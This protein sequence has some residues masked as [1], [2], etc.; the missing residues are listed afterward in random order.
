MPKNQLVNKK[1]TYLSFVNTLYPT[2]EQI[3]IKIKYELLSAYNEFQ[4]FRHFKLM[5]WILLNLY[6]NH[7][8]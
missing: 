4:I 1:N 3:G 2:S 8:S 7:F 5:Q 6:H